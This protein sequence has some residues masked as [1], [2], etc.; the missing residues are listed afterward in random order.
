MSSKQLSRGL[1]LS[2]WLPVAFGIAIIMTESTKYFGLAQTSGPLR[3]LWESLFGPV[4]SD[5]QWYKMHG[6]IRKTGHMT[7]YGLLGVVLFRAAFLTLRERW[8]SYLNAWLCCMTFALGGVLIVA[9]ADETH[10]LFIPGRTGTR[11]DVM[12]DLIGAAILQLIVGAFLWRR[13]MEQHVALPHT[14]HPAP[15]G[16]TD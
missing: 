2:A 11:I 9:S 14:P 5:A 6:W 8:S 7:G 1:L 16:T 10:Q 13:S 12:I 4:S 3:H 15:T